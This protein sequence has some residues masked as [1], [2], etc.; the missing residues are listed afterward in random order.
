[1]QMGLF[2]PKFVKK[3]VETPGAGTPSGTPAPVTESPASVSA[4]P[5][6]EKQESVLELRKRR[7]AEA[8]SDQV[9]LCSVCAKYVK[10]GSN[11][12]NC[13][14]CG[15]PIYRSSG[16]FTNRLSLRRFFLDSVINA[17]KLALYV[18]ITQ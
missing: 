8:G 13:P 10:K 16:I 3:S 15:S 4:P 17:I 9:V 12:M 6:Q 7:R 2:G 11:T 1:M 18:G 14:Y 5:V